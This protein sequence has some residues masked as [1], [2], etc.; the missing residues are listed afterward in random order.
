M[1]NR[2]VAQP[3]RY[4]LGGP[5]RLSA[6]A[7][8]QVRGTDY[9]LITPGYMRQVF[10]LPQPLGQHIYV[11]GAFEAGQMRSPDGATTTR[12]DLYFG[13]VAET[14]LGVITF[15]PSFGFQGQR[16][17]VFTIGKFF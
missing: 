9:W 1:F 3:F 11:G 4:T 7:I 2:A 12:E 14:P 6:E 16:K 10:S 5:L 13:V 15:A 8:D 17:F